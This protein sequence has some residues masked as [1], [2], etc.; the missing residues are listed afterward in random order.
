MKKYE[1]DLA[2]ML[3]ESGYGVEEKI[4]LEELKKLPTKEQDTY[5]RNWDNAEIEEYVRTVVDK[6]LSE[7]D[8]EKIE[9]VLYYKRLDKMCD[10]ILILSRCTVFFTILTAVSLILSIVSV[11]SLFSAF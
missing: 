6:S 7:E 11:V 3:I 4:S 10:N 9:K 2:K 8:I 5:A 1:K